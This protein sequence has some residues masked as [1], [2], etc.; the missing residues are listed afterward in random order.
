MA[1]LFYYLVLAPFVCLAVSVHVRVRV[2]IG[3]FAHLIFACSKRRGWTK[4]ISSHN[5]SITVFIEITYNICSDAVCAEVVILPPLKIPICLYCLSFGT[6]PN[7][8]Y[9]HK[10]TF[11]LI[12]FCAKKAVLY[13]DSSKY[14]INENYFECY[15]HLH[16]LS[17]PLLC[18][19]PVGSRSEKSIYH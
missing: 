13:S 18:E 3:V 12:S 6:Q 4:Q 16:V 15:H 5:T 2:W 14:L 10:C 1:F 9:R 8:L 19:L 11:E 17:H 7:L